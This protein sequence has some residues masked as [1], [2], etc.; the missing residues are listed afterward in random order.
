MQPGLGANVISASMNHDAAES[1]LNEISEDD[2]KAK[3]INGEIN[4]ASLKDG[5]DVAE[6]RQGRD[7][8]RVFALAALLM[9]FAES[10]VAWRLPSDAEQ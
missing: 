6:L 3:F 9:L 7:L 2:L 8:W 10:L 5:F 4:V 1:D